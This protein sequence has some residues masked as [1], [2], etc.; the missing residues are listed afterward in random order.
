MEGYEEASRDAGAFESG[1]CVCVIYSGEAEHFMY[2]TSFGKGAK[3]R[4]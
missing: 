2:E 4:G 1:A 3:K